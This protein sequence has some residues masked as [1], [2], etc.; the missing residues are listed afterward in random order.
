M[1]R[2]LLVA[3]LALAAGTAAHAT[4]TFAQDAAALRP[5][6]IRLGACANAGDV[7][8][9]LNGAAVPDG[10]QYGQSDATAV[11]QSATV[12]PVL[13]PDLLYSPHTV[14]VYS[15]PDEGNVPAACGDIGG[16]YG[17]GGTLAVGLTPLNG[18]RIDGVAYFS[19]VPTG[20][21]TMVTLLLTAD[22]SGRD[23]PDDSADTTADTG[24]SGGSPGGA[25]AGEDGVAGASGQNGADGQDGA[26]GQPG[27]PGQGGRGGDGGEGG[28]GGRGGDGGDGGNGGA[29]RGG[30][31]GDGGAGGA[32]ADATS[33][34]N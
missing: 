24:D 32:G 13:L 10:D 18:S 2:P 16:A 27:E 5:A 30:R 4:P 21:A 17:A 26:D 33:T 31:G 1:H 6:E 25:T 23:R 22:H 15:T 19:P 20:D 14:V 9:P 7:V 12:V 8:T 3:A 28:K 29:G 34:S 11:E